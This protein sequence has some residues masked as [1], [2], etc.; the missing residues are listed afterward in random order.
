MERP[1]VRLSLAP[2]LLAAGLFACTDAP[3]V[4]HSPPHEEPLVRVAE[5]VS[6]PDP[7]PVSVSEPATV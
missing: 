7:V 2:A 6:A 3:T 5:S 4:D 1:I